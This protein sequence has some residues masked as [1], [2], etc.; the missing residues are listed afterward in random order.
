M[1]QS[2]SVPNLNPLHR[3]RTNIINLW[4]FFLFLEF[5]K[6]SRFQPAACSCPRCTSR[7][8]GRSPPKSKAGTFLFG[9]Y[10]SPPLLIFISKIYSDPFLSH[11]FSI[12]NYYL[13]NFHWVLYYW[14]LKIMNSIFMRN[15]SQ[16]YS[17]FFVS[18]L[19]R[20]RN[21]SALTWLLLSS[22]KCFNRLKMLGSNFVMLIEF[23]LGS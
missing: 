5:S 12:E 2:D 19:S 1:N 13:S 4:A 22:L 7:P 18:Q 9:L 17:D 3:S 20:S 10:H 23:H 8:S 14:N 21:L 6:L 11:W 15:S 16:C